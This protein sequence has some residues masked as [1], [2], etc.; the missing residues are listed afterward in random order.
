MKARR[1]HGADQGRRTSRARP[2]A[3]SR[4]PRSSS[5]CEAF[6]NK[7]GGVSIKEYGTTDEAYAD[8][9]AGRLDAVAGS[10]PNLA[11]LVKTPSRNLRDGRALQVR[12]PTLFSWVLRKDADSESFAKAINDAMLKMT[13]DGRSQG[14]PGEVVR[15]LYRAAAEKS[16][17][18]SEHSRRP[19]GV[20]CPPASRASTVTPAT[21]LRLAGISHVFPDDLRRQLRAAALACALSRVLIS[22]LGIALGH[23]DRHADLRRAGCRHSSR[24]ALRRLLGQLLARRAAA[25]PAPRWSTTCCRSSA[26]TCRPMV[27]AVVTV[28][29]CASAYKPEILAWRHPA[30]LPSGQT[31]A[32]IAFG[33][34]SRE[35]WIRMILPQAFSCR[36]RRLVNEV[37]LLVKASLARLG[38][39]HHSRSC[40][41]AKLWPRRRSARSRATSPAALHLPDHQPLAVP[42]RGRVPR[43]LARALI[44]LSIFVPNTGRSCSA[45]SN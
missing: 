19:I 45:A 12:Q 3:S 25:R 28:G 20:R 11:Y 44:D 18:K 13:D 16:P 43:A 30:A 39:R 37:I 40:R 24:C 42:A 22:V 35:R 14:N 33:M 27:A 29:I 5:S 15:R 1:Q 10:M 41:V 2:S 17:T 9:A 32:A 36:C 4:G 31:E 7:L 34:R 21:R 23:G 6:G 8:L 26:S 38:G